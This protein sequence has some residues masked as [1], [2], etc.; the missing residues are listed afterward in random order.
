MEGKEEENLL[1][2]ALV[3]ANVIPTPSILDSSSDLNVREYGNLTIHGLNLK[4]AIS[5][6]FLFSPEIVDYTIMSP[7]PLEQNAVYIMLKCDVSGP[8]YVVS[9]DTGGGALTLNAKV[10]NIVP[11]YQPSSVL[12]DTSDYSS[13]SV[14]PLSRPSSLNYSDIDKITSSQ[15]PS[16]PIIV[17]VTSPISYLAIVGF[18]LFVFSTILLYKN[19]QASTGWVAQSSHYLLLNNPKKWPEAF[20]GD[21]GRGQIIL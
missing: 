21:D 11:Q 19:S 4:G 17:H 10:A 5:I 3:V 2:T 1:P 16:A 7:L 12:S 14:H 18:F 8:L 13:I 9:V 6:A 20:R 15:D